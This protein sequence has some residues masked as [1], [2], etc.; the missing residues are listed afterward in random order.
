M[1][2]KYNNL[3][4]DLSK[5]EYADLLNLFNLDY[6]FNLAD[7]K[8]AK[9]QV[10]STHPDKSGLD[11]QFFLFFANAYK[12][13]YQVYNF[14]LK[15]Q[16]TS[17]RDLSKENVDYIANIEENNKILLDKFNK[18]K[19]LDKDFNIWFNKLF[20]EV[21]IDNEY[22]DTGYS[23][24]LSNSSQDIPV[25][26]NQNDI[27]N[28]I[29]NKKKILRDNQIVQHRDISEFNNNS[30]CDLTNRQP[31]SY[32]SGIFEKLQYNDLKQAHTETVV[33]VTDSD[34]KT[35]YNS[36]ED[37]RFKRGI[38]IDPLSNQ[39]SK[40]YLDRKSRNDNFINS[41]RA[42]DMIKQQEAIENANQKWWSKLKLLS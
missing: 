14:R 41:N 22:N 2:T 42:Y 31:E 5:Y 1:D 8:I 17:D 34:L 32:S 30:Y 39:E 36:I 20:E 16:D 25:L 35:S 37:A 23:D 13:I 24:W 4:L 40:N 21:K 3:E 15:T 29:N 38:T 28:Y 33:P 19:N 12:I 10:L 9:R 27:N 26:N 11:K 18:N 7:L 6:N